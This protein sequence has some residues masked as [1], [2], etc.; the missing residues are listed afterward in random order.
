MITAGRSPRTSAGLLRSTQRY[1][2]ASRDVIRAGY[3]TPADRSSFGVFAPKQLK[4][5]LASVVANVS[6]CPKPPWWAV[7]N[8]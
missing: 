1:L 6:P 8:H 5:R 2:P 4:E 3:L 7:W